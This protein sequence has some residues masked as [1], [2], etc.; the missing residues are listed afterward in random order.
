MESITL[1]IIAEDDLS[2]LGIQTLL[3]SY[4]GIHIYQSAVSMET[5]EPEELDAKDVLLFLI[6]EASQIPD[7]S[8]LHSIKA[9][10]LVE[11]ELNMNN[12]LSHGFMGV[13]SRSSSAEAINTAIRAVAEGLLVLSPELRPELTSKQNQEVLLA[14]LTPRELE[15]LNLL[16]Q[17]NSN[18]QLAIKLDIS[19]NTVKYHVNQLLSKFG[20]NSR[21]EVVVQAI[22]AGLVVM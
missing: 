16:V 2:R 6:D 12:F 3:S 9:V 8:L 19:E 18:K 7:V 17:G 13:I 10:A 21:T 14:D 11:K 1:H 20:V 5:L 4:Q 15:V 22:Q